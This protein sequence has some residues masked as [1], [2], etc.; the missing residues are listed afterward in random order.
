M[1]SGCQ[2]RSILPAADGGGCFAG[3]LDWG[4]AGCCFVGFMALG[5]AWGSMG[6]HDNLKMQEILVVVDMTDM[7]LLGHSFCFMNVNV[8][9]PIINHRISQTWGVRIQF[10][11]AQYREKKLKEE[12]E[13]KAPLRG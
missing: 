11:Q 6:Q 12:L 7:T 1:P 5:A 10:L 9:C 2:G 3:A 13:R 8:F 4:G